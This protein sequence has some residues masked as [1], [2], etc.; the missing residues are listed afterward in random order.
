M[1]EVRGKL[2]GAILALWIAPLF[3]LGFSGIVLDSETLLPIPGAL[4]TIG[5]KNTY[6]D[7]GGKFEMN[8]LPPGDFV[9]EVEHIA[10]QRTE[11]KIVL[12]EGYDGYIS[13]TLAPKVYSSEP[14][15]SFAKRNGDTATRPLSRDAIA[16][17][18]S[19]PGVS[20]IEGNGEIGVS[21]RGSRPKDVLVVVDGIPQARNER[22]YTD[23]ASLNL[24]SIDKVE[25]FL[26]CIPAEYSALAP[27]G[28]LLIETR[29]FD[30]SRASIE[31]NR[32]SFSESKLAGDLQFMPHSDF[33]V[34]VGSSFSSA[35]GDFSYMDAETTAVRRN[36]SRT[37][38]ALSLD[39]EL[40]AKLD[41]L[42]LSANYTTLK[43][44]M[45]GDLNHPTPMAKRL[46]E[47]LALALR[48]NR[49][50]PFGINSNVKLSVSSGNNNF[51]I[52]RPYV[53]VPVDAENIVGRRFAQLC[54]SRS[55]YGFTPQLGASY[56]RETYEHLNFLAHDRDI[57]AKPREVSAVWVQGDFNRKILQGN[58]IRGFAS[59]RLD[60][61]SDNSL[62]YNNLSFEASISQELSYF[63]LAA[64][65]GYS[66]AF[67][68]PDFVDVYWLRDA[69]AEGNPDLAP[70]LAKK[71]HLRLS[72]GFRSRIVRIDCETD[73]FDRS[74]DS[75]II[76]KKDFDGIYRP[77]NQAREESRGR[78]DHIKI[79]LANSLEL[80][81]S[82]VI[83][84]SIHR[85]NEAIVDSMWIP[86]K[87]P[88]HQKL[89]MKYFN[90]YISGGLSGEWVGKRYTLIANTKWT[91]PYEVWNAYLEVPIPHDLFIFSLRL[92]C[93]NIFDERYEILIDYPLPGRN[94][95]VFAKIEYLF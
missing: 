35:E 77:K 94:W 58:A 43:E 29:K 59:Y 5:H 22:G 18:A 3:G 2:W 57:V 39:L 93:N 28:V 78:E 49:P 13:I 1:P 20:V 79:A 8:N 66:E 75:V 67:H 64:S 56:T 53:Y 54:L 26:E 38:R 30:A 27:A 89:S 55:I 52:P 31:L 9:I 7:Q 24:E 76:W 21:V 6:A 87:A 15:Y 86:F 82:N 19:I 69:F 73:I 45:P 84:S 95:S 11:E 60:N 88:Y 72:A 91:A 46:G 83:L 51:Y 4:I 90:K 34:G 17:I 48:W 71:H 70:E 65:A 81:W 32:A 40:N 16:E 33:S 12:R 36:N 80:E 47:N 42:A 62:S 10:Y 14:V 85:T 63:I 74:I 61:S 44:G 68:F 25:L 41:T 23:I 92:E 50:L 37:T